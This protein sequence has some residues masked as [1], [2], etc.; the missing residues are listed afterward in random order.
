MKHTTTAWILFAL[1]TAAATSARSADIE[2][3]IRLIEEAET[4]AREPGVLTTVLAKEGQ[5]VTE[6]EVLAQIEDVQARFDKTRA[7]LELEIAREDAENDVAVRAA[8]KAAAVAQNDWQRAQRT[9][10]KNPNAISES[11]VEHRRLTAEHAELEVERAQRDFRI[12]R[13][14]RQL[15]ENECRFAEET[16]GRHKV[17]AP[18]GGMVVEVH[19]RRGEWVE[20]G[21]RVLRIVRIDR[22]RAEG[23]VDA[24][25][26]RSGWMGAPVLVSIR[27]EEDSTEQFSGKIVFVSPEIDPVN[28]QVAVWAEIDNP[29][30]LLRPGLRATMTIDT[31]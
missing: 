16:L 5:M 10:D 19:R 13:V 8:Q 1:I 12:A 27:L 30:L 2:V 25:Q 7:E 20:P 14:K 24:R 18:L 4:P 28:G 11:E 29:D 9:V 26:A 22:L 15:K 23:F 3:F 21:E 6:G 17:V 31:K